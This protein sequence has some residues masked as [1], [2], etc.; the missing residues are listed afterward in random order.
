MQRKNGRPATE[1]GE[2]DLAR[3]MAGYLE[4]RIDAFDALH[5]ALAGRMR[6]YL[7]SLCRDATTADDLVQETFLQMHR[8]RR[9]YEPGRPVMPWVF[10][11]ARHVYLM[12]RRRTARRL[13]FEDALAAETR[14]LD[15]PADALNRLAADDELRRAL[16][17]C[18]RISA[19]ALLL[20]HVRGRSFRRDRRAARP[21]SERGENARVPRHEASARAARE[22]EMSDRKTARFGS[23]RDIAPVRPLAPTR[24]PDARARPHRHRDS[25]RDTA[26]ARVPRRH[27][28]DRIRSAHGASRSARQWPGSRSLPSRCTSRC[29]AGA[30]R[31]TPRAAARARHG[32]AGCNPR[33]DHAS[34]HVGPPPGLERRRGAGCFRVSSLAALPALAV[35]AAL[36]ARGLPAAARHRRRALRPRLQA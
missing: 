5:A 32:V 2:A 23:Q 36:A 11:I 31:G 30:L 17:M 3:H 21:P 1:S 35:A 10:A 34:L 14:R 22:A 6:A 16:E 24:A 33:D 12:H 9:T 15:S 28:G 7:W 26:A 20:H 29:R 13:R 25:G 19:S 4:G 18:R 8:S 27:G